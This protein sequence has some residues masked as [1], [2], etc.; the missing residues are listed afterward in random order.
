[1]KFKFK[2]HAAQMTQIPSEILMN[3]LL[4]DKKWLLNK[5]KHQQQ[6]DYKMKKLLAFSKSIAIPNDKE[7]SNAN[8]PNQYARVKHLA[9]GEDVIK[10]NK[11]QNYAFVDD[12]LE[13]AMKSSSLYEIDEDVDYEYW[14]SSYDA[15]A[16]LSIS[17]SLHNK[18]KNLLHLPEKYHISILDGGVDTCVF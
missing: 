10:D 11:Y 1:M 5:G 3:L 17:N 18:C 6:E 16:T 4:E 12:F 8:L 2:I 15:H 7:I 9:K 13:E 14:S